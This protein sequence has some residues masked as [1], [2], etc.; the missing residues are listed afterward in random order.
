MKKISMLLFAVAILLMGCSN[1]TNNG[2]KVDNG[3]AKEEKKGAEANEKPELGT[4]QDYDGNTY[5]TVKIGQQEWMAE[6]MRAEHDRDGKAI[7]I[8]LLSET[9]YVKPY[10]YCPDNNS[11]NVKEYGYLYNWPAA[12]KVCPEGWHLPSDAEWTQLTDYLKDNGYSCGGEKEYV[13]KALA[14]K[15]GW[16]SSS[17]QCDVGNNPSTNNASGFSALPAGSYYGYYYYFGYTAPFWSATEYYVSY[18]WFRAL[19]CY[20]AYVGRYYGSKS[21]GRSVRCVR[22]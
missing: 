4:M 16:E 13:A 15:T 19:G 1:G 8:A 11:D 21:D 22:D 20:Y 9:G 17:D 7:A 5:K 12:M 14:S 10:L 3:G 2:K 18:A 6:N